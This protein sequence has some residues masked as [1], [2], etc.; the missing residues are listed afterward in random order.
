MDLPR[1]TA[2]IKGLKLKFNMATAPQ[3]VL[4]G[5]PTRSSRQA[6]AVI[7]LQSLN[8][9]LPQDAAPLDFQ[10]FQ[11]LR[12]GAGPM[13]AGDG[14]RQQLAQLHREAVWTKL[15][16]PLAG[17]HQPLLTALLVP[18]QTE[19]LVWLQV[20]S[21]DLI[22]LADG[23]HFVPAPGTQAAEDWGR[24]WNAC[25][26]PGLFRR[27]RFGQGLSGPGRGR[28]TSREQGINPIQAR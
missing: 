18:L 13:D 6:T 19:A 25:F 15:H 11:T 5:V 3:I 9:V 7:V 16:D 26:G 4:W 20:Q 2:S 17:Q 24:F 28:Q 27:R 23:Q 12:S 21:L 10:D 14:H 22:T 8:I 1:C